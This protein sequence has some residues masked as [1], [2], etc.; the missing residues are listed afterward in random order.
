MI[1]KLLLRI[2]FVWLIATPSAFQA[3]E[4]PAPPPPAPDYFPRT[5]KEFIST[6]GGFRVCFPGAPKEETQVK[7]GNEMILFFHSRISGDPIYFPRLPAV[8]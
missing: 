1:G 7:P 3:Q 4:M 6:E 2:V 5:W 8:V